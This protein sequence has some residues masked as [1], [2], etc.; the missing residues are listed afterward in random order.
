MLKPTNEHRLSETDLGSP[1]AP[2]P[3]AAWSPVPSPHVAPGP[4]GEAAG[5]TRQQEGRLRSACAGQTTRADLHLVSAAG[6]LSGKLSVPSL[7]L[8]LSLTGKPGKMAVTCF[9]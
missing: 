9:R 5:L 4:A 6:K 3:P 7:S 2:V 8:L 1:P